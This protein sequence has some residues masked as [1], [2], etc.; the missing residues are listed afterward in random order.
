MK[1]SLFFGISFGCIAFVAVLFIVSAICG[2]TT[3]ILGRGTPGDLMKSA[4]AMILVSLGYS[5]PALIYEKDGVALG[6]Q[7]LIHMAVGTAI[8]CT[9]AYAA[10]WMPRNSLR[11]T[12]A[13][14]AIAFLSSAVMWAA[15]YFSMKRAAKKMNQKIKEKQR[16]GE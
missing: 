11:D 13:Y 4:G 14:V 6:M 8:F 15:T 1:K 9:V 16:P 10:E 5:L 2:D 7:I 3:P 12:V